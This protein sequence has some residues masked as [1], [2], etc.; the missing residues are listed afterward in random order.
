MRT[1]RIRSDFALVDSDGQVNLLVEVKRRWDLT[2]DEAVEFHDWYVE[3]LPTAIPFMLVTPQVAYLWPARATQNK[4][5]RDGY[6]CDFR[7][8]CRSRLSSRK[9]FQPSGLRALEVS[10]TRLG[11]VDPRIYHRDRPLSLGAPRL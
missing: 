11:P 2:A 7:Q 4:A 9:R 5:L 1:H 3:R 6:H 8:L 10:Q